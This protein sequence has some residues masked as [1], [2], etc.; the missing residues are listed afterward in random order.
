MNRGTSERFGGNTFEK[1]PRFMQFVIDKSPEPGFLIES[2]GRV[3]YANEAACRCLGYTREELLGMTVWDIDPD[4]S[5]DGWEKLWETIK[6]GGA[7]TFESRHRG[8]DGHVFPVEIGSRHLEFEGL[9]LNCAFVRNIS[10]RRPAED[11]DLRPFKTTQEQLRYLAAVR[12]ITLAISSTLETSAVL[13]ALVEKLDLLPYPVATLRLVAKETGQLNCVRC[14][15]LNEAEWQ[16]DTESLSNIVF[17]TGQVLVSEDVRYDSR[18]TKPHLVIKHGLVSFLG[19][20]ITVRG[21]RLGVLSFYTKTRHNFTAD[22]IDVLGLIAVQAGV[23]I[24]NSQLHEQTKQNTARLAAANQQLGALYE[25]TSTVSQS[26]DLDIV[27]QQVIRKITEIFQFD[28]TR[29]FLYD[30]Q[31]EELGLRSSFERQP[32]WLEVKTFKK[33]AGIVGGVAG[34]GEALVFEDANTDPRYL[35]HSQ[36]KNTVK[37]KHS[38][39]GAFPIKSRSQTWGTILCIG[40]Q[41]RKLSTDEFQL[42]TS[43]AN[44]IGI[45]V[46]NANLFEE[47]RERATDLEA[48]NAELQEANRAKTDFVNA[49]SHELRTPLTASMRYVGLL[50]DGYGGDVTKTQAETLENVNH[51]SALLLKLISDLL[52]LGQL[53][54]GKLSLEISEAPLDEIF[55]HVRAYAEQLD[56]QK[57]PDLCWEIEEGLPSLTTDHVKLEEILQNLIGNAYKFTAKGQIIVRVRNLKGE[58]RLEFVVE[59]TGIGIDLSEVDQV[60]DPFHQSSEAHKGHLG[61]VGLGLSI[62]KKYLGLMHGQI[63]V[64]S[65]PGQGS[66]F[67]FTLP[68]SI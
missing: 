14:Y 42:I 6:T 8:K 20:P 45:A 68:Y 36:T 13:D 54:A 17:D 46:E 31:M 47:T 1:I 16:P 5:E 41:P 9:V 29:I 43:M 59:D 15:N 44:Q 28:T 52:T 65:S 26:L 56:H 38:F 63:R 64:E 61:G 62:V 11:E 40:R 30:R 33:G 22:E 34:T 50:L 19:L 18:T 55:R 3:G 7:C 53:E 12:E 49:I 23:A 25:I 10:K 51:Q 37:K 60:F 21:N 57:V 58:E 39:L 66:K 2:D 27:L 24:Y 48:L 67:I 32:Q 4:L 35:A